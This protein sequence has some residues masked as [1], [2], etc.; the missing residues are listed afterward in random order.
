VK[1]FG[2]VGDGVAD[3]T[4]AIQAAIDYCA[5]FSHWATL[6]L[7]GRHKIT[8]SLIVNR[9][10]NNTLS[11]FRMI[12]NGPGAGFYV[13]GN[14]TVFDSTIPVT[15][16]PQSEWVTFEGVTFESSSFFNQAYVLS[17]KFLR[18][19]FLNCYFK[20]FR[21]QTST[22]YAQTLFFQNCN[23]RNS[24]SGFIDCVG[25][26]DVVFDSCIIE[27]N[28]RL[29]RCIDAAR[30]TNGLRIV[31]SV[32]EGQQETTIAITGASGFVYAHNHV[33]SNVINDLNFFAGGLQ[34]KSISIIGNYVYNPS[35]AL[36]YY[37]PTDQVF[38]AGNFVNPGTI[39]SNAVQVTNLTSISDSATT[40]ADATITSKVNGVVRYGAAQEDWTHSANHFT[41]SAA[42]NFGFGRAPIS[43][44]R[45]SFQGADQTSS[46]FAAVAYDSVGNVIFSARN[47]RM[48]MLP[49]L[50]NYANDAAAA[51]AGVP[52]SGLY[53]NGSVVQVRVT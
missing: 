33:E 2:A 19:K 51:A 20:L 31:N 6:I 46:N 35:G 17:Q 32:I 23:I 7:T 48:F 4:A 40:I 44:V 49:A 3:D 14:V 12:A 43:A 24:Q 50:N 27:N 36:C 34:N 45:A 42:G 47:D 9:L 1:D 10:V 22:I 13:A 25:L 15:T 21:C 41:K 29:V 11:E 30:G 8:S 16:D 37:G 18:C 53:R 52:V 28:Y 39:H 5:T 38:S 26:Y